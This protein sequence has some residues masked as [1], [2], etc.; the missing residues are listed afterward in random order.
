MKDRE[1]RSNCL[2]ADSEDKEEVNNRVGQTGSG[3]EY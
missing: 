2:E 1:R 3:W